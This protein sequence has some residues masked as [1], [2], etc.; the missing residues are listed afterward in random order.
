MKTILVFSNS[1][2]AEFKMRKDLLVAL[3]NKWRVVLCAPFTEFV[4]E[5]RGLVHNLIN[6]DFE[7]RGTNVWNDLLL[8]KRYHHIIKSIKPS[9]ILTFTIKPNIYANIAASRLGIPYFPNITGV[10]KAFQT[11]DL[12]SKIVIRL[13]RIAMRDVS[14][15]FFQN[16]VNYELF[17][18]N[19]I[20]NKMQNYQIIPGSGVNTDDFPFYDMNHSY[21]LKFVFLG[22]IMQEKGMD[23]YCTMASNFYDDERVEFY[24]IG[25]MLEDYTEKFRSAGIIYYKQASDIKSFVKESHVI[26]NPSHHEGMS[27]ILLE[28]ASMGRPLLASNIPGCRKIIIEGENGMLFQFKNIEEFIE[29]I[30]SFLNMSFDELSEMGRNSRQIVKNKFNKTIVSEKYLNELSKVLE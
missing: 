23:E 21:P 6:I 9:A 26:V 14:C 25:K 13:Y 19:N 3:S 15:I 28:G 20:I 1:T 29:K 11:E 22:R 5:L 8:M 10:G 16:S 12:I 18:K 7:G 30:H 24:A 2:Y 4:D 27:N 17:R